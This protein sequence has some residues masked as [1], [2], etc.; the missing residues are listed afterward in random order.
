M[1]EKKKKK[2]VKI[3]LEGGKHL[4]KTFIVKS[5]SRYPF[6]LPTQSPEPL[7]E[8][9]E[10]LADFDSEKSFETFFAIIE[11][12]MK[13]Y[14]S[15]GLL[16]KKRFRQRYFKLFDIFCD[17]KD[18]FIVKRVLYIRESKESFLR[19]LEKST[20]RRKI[21]DGM[22]TLE[23]F[24]DGIEEGKE[25][26]VGI[27]WSW[28]LSQAE[29]G[30]VGGEGRPIVLVGS[31]RKRDVNWYGTFIKNLDPSLRKEFEIEI[32]KEREVEIIGVNE[33]SIEKPITVLT[34]IEDRDGG[35]RK[36]VLRATEE[37]LRVFWNKEDYSEIKNSL[38]ECKEDSLCLY[39]LENLNKVGI[40]YADY[41][42]V[43]SMEEIRRRWNN[44]EMVIF[45]LCEQDNIAMN[46]DKEW[47]PEVPRTII[48]PT[49]TPLY[50]EYGLSPEEIKRQIIRSIF[51]EE[52]HLG[53]IWDEGEAERYSKAK[54]KKVF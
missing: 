32:E 4:S 21:A 33:R 34:F 9:L 38:L 23:R 5:P 6:N 39:L 41:I 24:D 12:R 53:G 26:G 43:G 11:D 44:N 19:K 48:V 36:E 35:E 30:D 45:R 29:L 46:L 2:E 1:K 25:R 18:P 37:V 50:Y 16:D 47:Y 20:M 52:A 42:Y 28:N 31:V 8:R 27:Y 22:K 40:A 15:Y 51:H 14:N 10:D 13:G 7:R 3:V 17:F 54:C 49:D